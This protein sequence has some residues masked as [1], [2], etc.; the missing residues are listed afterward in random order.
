MDGSWT[1]TRD[2]DCLTATFADGDFAGMGMT[3]DVI[4]AVGAYLGMNTSLINSYVNGLSALGI[5]SGNFSIADDEAAGTTTVRMNIAAPWDMKELDEMVFDDV[6]LD[7][8]DP[9][10]EEFTSMGGGIGKLR[11]VANGSANDLTV[12]LGEYGELDELA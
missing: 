7:S 6:T 10:G 12:L 3:L 11:M 5:E 1:F 4:E 8:Y 2:G 9:L